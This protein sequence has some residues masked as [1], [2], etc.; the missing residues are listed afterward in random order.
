MRAGGEVRHVAWRRAGMF[1]AWPTSMQGWPW[2]WSKLEER[3]GVGW[4][5]PL[6]ARAGLG[7]RVDRRRGEGG[8]DPPHR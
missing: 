8:G 5:G 7:T 2:A 6:A 4:V 3:V 1:L